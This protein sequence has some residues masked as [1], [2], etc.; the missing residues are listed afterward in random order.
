VR[1]CRGSCEAGVNGLWPAARNLECFDA[2]HCC[3]FRTTTSI[4]TAH[5]TYFT[6][7]G[8]ERGEAYGGNQ[9]GG[10]H[11]H[12]R[13]SVHFYGDTLMPYI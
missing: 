4:Y 9:G 6:P 3:T 13:C 1:S 2:W 10:R 11:V 12:I 8:C 5:I 7:D